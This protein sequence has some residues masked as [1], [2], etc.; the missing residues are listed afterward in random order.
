VIETFELVLD[1][2]GFK[3][4]SNDLYPLL[5]V[6]F[7]LRSIRLE[8]FA[9]DVFALSRVEELNLYGDSSD[10]HIEEIV[11]PSTFPALR[12]L[13]LVNVDTRE[14]L[15][16]LLRNLEPQLDLI[17]MDEE[18]IEILAAD[19]FD[20]INRKTLFHQHYR[21]YTPFPNVHSYRLLSSDAP[22]AELSTWEDLEEIVRTSTTPLPSVLYLAGCHTLDLHNPALKVPRQRFSDVCKARNMEVVYEAKPDWNGD[23]GRPKEFWRRMR[24]RKETSA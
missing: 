10:V 22:E 14:D 6:S 8:G 7:S 12:V 24:G 17:W 1:G 19:V 18:D 20:K 13:S 3:A 23:F 11:S 15:S 21:I 5:A 4:E 16:T 9:T 2:Q